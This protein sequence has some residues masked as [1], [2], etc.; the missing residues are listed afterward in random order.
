MGSATISYISPRSLPLFYQKPPFSQAASAKKRDCSRSLPS[1]SS[2]QLL[3]SAGR[4]RTY[5][6]LVNSQ[7]RYRCATAE[8]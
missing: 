6:L 8:Y 4:I 5:N 1:G 7:P 2:F 3:G